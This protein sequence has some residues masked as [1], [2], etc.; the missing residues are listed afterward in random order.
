[1]KK[2]E[3]RPAIAAE[4]ARALEPFARGGAPA[5]PAADAAAEA[6]AA[7]T[8]DSQKASPTR[9]DEGGTPGG[10]ARAKRSGKGQPVP[11][12][13]AGKKFP[14]L[15]VTGVGAL[16]AAVAVVAGGVVILT[17]FHKPGTT[18]SVASA[19][20]QTIPK[21]PT[22]STSPEPKPEPKPPAPSGQW[23]AQLEL[24][25]GTE[26]RFTGAVFSDGGRRVLG[27]TVSSLHEWD[28]ST[29]KVARPFP[30]TGTPGGMALTSDG[31]RLLTGGGGPGRPLG[32]LADGGGVR[33]LEGDEGPA[34]SVC[35]AGHR[36][37]RSP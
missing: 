2:P 21:A 7:I 18:P 13:P 30:G 26:G 20:I 25:P 11:R 6:W 29:G 8:E 14:V 16:L 35:G 22:T 32:G 27:G 34:P 1:A 9:S 33:G 31:K 17:S 4:L 37:P 24:P 3:E 12:Q 23:L 5:S 36:A 28:L 10:D 19:P 15:L